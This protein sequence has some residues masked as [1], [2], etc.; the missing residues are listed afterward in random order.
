VRGWFHRHP[1]REVLCRLDKEENFVDAA[2]ER[3][4]RATIDQRIE[5]NTLD[6]ALHYLRVILN[7]TIL[8]KLRA[9]SRPKEVSLPWPGFPGEPLNEDATSSAEVWESVQTEPL[10]VR[11]QR[12]AY[13]LFHCGFKPGE[14][15]H[16]CSQEFS[17]V[18]EIYRLRRNI[19][20]RML[21]NVD[22]LQ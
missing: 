9:S 13:L 16:C 11:E 22:H 10:N 17:D 8:D 21:C 3:F 20:E 19:I 4:W 5:F 2:F 18:C 7:G 15:V 1:H 14:I 6:T 12:L